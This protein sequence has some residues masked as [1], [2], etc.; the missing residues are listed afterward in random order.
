[1]INSK[2]FGEI[3]V[4]DHSEPIYVYCLKNDRISVEVLTY[5]ATISAIRIPDR[6][7]NISDIVLGFS[8]LQGYLGE[9]NPYFGATVGR[10]CNRIE[11]ARFKIK[12]KLYNIS[13]NRPPLT[14]H[15]G[16]HGLDKKIW[17]AK[18]EGEKL[19]MTCISYHLEEGF[20]GNIEA[21]VIFELTDDNELKM[22]LRAKTSEATPINFTN[23]SYFNLAGHETGAMDVMDHEVMLSADYYTEV[24]NDS[25][26]TGE[27]KSVTGTYLD[28]RTQR[29]LGFLINNSPM[30]GYD[31]N[32]CVNGTGLRFVARAV[33]KKTGRTLE[34]YSN[35]P[36]V[37]FYTGNFLNNIRG[38]NNA[39]YNKHSGF[40]FETQN[41]P[42]AVNIPSF[43]NSVLE[44]CN[45]YCHLVNYKFTIGSSSD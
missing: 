33:H 7:G 14:L 42:N 39:V 1:M 41:Y 18:V 13:A 8:D 43:P 35:Q 30:N 28:L 29:N 45:E 20:P 11:N 38:K 34:V 40:C 19:V 21:K 44:P 2:V 24:N 5:G 16:F 6:H 26:P 36:G 15:G 4:G 23:H 17:N 37:Q 32:F 31:I 22:E 27:I 9:N 10:V 25:I 3:K 12:D